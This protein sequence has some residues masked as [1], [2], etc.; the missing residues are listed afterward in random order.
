MSHTA[1]ALPAIEP[2]QAAPATRAQLE[3][4]QRKLGFLPNMFRTM[5]NSPVAL[6]AYL[7]LAGAASAGTLDARRREL[8]AL[9]VGQANEC[10][11]CV[12]AH[13]A[14]GAGAGL[15]AAQIAAARHGKSS[16]PREQALL[17]LSAAILSHRGHVPVAELDAFRAAG[18]DDAA[19]LEV[20]V[21]VVLNVY[22]NWTNHL[23]R[24]TIDFPVVELQAA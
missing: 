3:Q 17:R 4:L 16:D 22:T 7:Q 13:G 12:A 23:A 21:N 1:P 9:A 10:G 20:L 15:S 5:A 14:L 19:I 8:I 6:N 11:Y 18:Y 2:S 24:T